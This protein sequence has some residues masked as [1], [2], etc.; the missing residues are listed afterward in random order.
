MTNLVEQYKQVQAALGHG[1]HDGHCV[2]EKPTGMH[3]NGGC[4]CLEDMTFSERQYVGRLL[5][6][7]QELVK[8]NDRLQTE[9]DAANE[10]N[11]E[12]ALELL[13]AHTQAQEAIDKLTKAVEGFE[14][15]ARLGNGDRLGNRIAQEYLTELTGGKDD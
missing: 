12:L 4:R 10:R 9:L 5:R 11:K 3:T 13:A 2:I 8:Q 6:I 15:L 1:C 14:Q 7:A